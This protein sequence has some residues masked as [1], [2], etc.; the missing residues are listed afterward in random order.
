M[1]KVFSAS[2]AGRAMRCHAS[3]NLSIAIEGWVPPEKDETLTNAANRGT[4]LHALFAGMWDMTPLE[5]KNFLRGIEY[6]EGLMA[7]RR[8]RKLIEQEE[9]AE[10]LTTR[11]TTTAD[12]VLYQN[13]ELHVIDFKTGKTPVEVIHNPQMLFYAAT[14]LKFAPKADG[15]HI[16]IVQPAAANIEEWFA[17]VQVIED[18]KLE[19]L[20]AEEAI[21]KKDTTFMVGDHCMFCD[22][23]PLGRGRHGS[24]ACPKWS[25]PVSVA[26]DVDAMFEED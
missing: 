25:A 9:T 4:Q 6:V 2:N 16:H 26:V 17:P 22:A 20:L 11:P 15:V 24:P 8:F 12:L 1:G 14:Y 19:T 21:L 7:Q 13:A 23:N 10:W 18:F 5:R 3:A